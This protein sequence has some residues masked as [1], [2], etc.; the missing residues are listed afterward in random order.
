MDQSIYTYIGLIASILI[1]ISIMMT[2]V[3]AFRIINLIGAST[4]AI[5][6]YLIESIPVFA[7][8]F[9]NT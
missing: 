4:F 5:Y 8:N 7:L 1:A 6:G 9:F 2:N 3:K